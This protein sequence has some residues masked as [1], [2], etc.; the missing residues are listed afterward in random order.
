MD[1]EREKS[2]FSDVHQIGRQPWVL[3]LQLL[4]GRMSDD[5]SP[6]DVMF[7]GSW[8]K[9]NVAGV[10]DGFRRPAGQRV[11]TRLVMPSNLRFAS[12]PAT[13]MRQTL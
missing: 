5:H 10:E 9:P 11:R 1:I 7:Y 13:S 2:L 4:I 8:P 3:V 12:G 6:F